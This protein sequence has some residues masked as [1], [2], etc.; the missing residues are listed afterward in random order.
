[1]DIRAFRSA[2][3]AFFDRKWSDGADRADEGALT[4]LP[5]PVSAKERSGLHCLDLAQL[6][7]KAREALE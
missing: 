2:A 3:R 4:A 1:M 6:G 5:L 7:E